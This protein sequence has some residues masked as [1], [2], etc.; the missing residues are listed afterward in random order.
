MRLFIGVPTYDTWAAE[1]GHS[2]ALAMV[3]IALNGD[4]ERL[5]LTRSESTILPAGRTDLVEDAIKEEATH[6]LWCDCDMTFKPAAVRSLLKHADLDIVAADYLKRRPP[7]L[8]VAQGMDGER[9]PAGDGLI[10]AH[11]VGLGLAL[12]RVDIFQ[13]LPKPWFALPW[14]EERNGFVGEDVWFCRH[15]REHGSQI[16]V[17]RDA[18]R[19]V[20]HIGKTTFRAP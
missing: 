12:T 15:A 18:S 5:R 3:D 13:L 14:N 10:E 16:Y 6:I 20:G 1:F 8:P 19:E 17:D 9:I 2:L 11:H 7:N 4:V